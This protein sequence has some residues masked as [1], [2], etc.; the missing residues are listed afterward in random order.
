MY[1]LLRVEGATDSLALAKSLV[2]DTRLGLA[3][4]IAFGPECEGYLRWCTARPPATLLA[5]V[6]RLQRYLRSA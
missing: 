1:V 3:P 4:G 2:T 5:G 6:E